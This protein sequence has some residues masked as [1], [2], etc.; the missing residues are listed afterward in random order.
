[1]M[2]MATE[3]QVSSTQSLLLSASNSV[4]PVELSPSHNEQ[5]ARANHREVRMASPVSEGEQ[6]NQLFKRVRLHVKENPIRVSEEFGRGTSEGP[7]F[8]TAERL[9]LGRRDSLSNF[10]KRRSSDLI[11]D[12]SDKLNDKCNVYEE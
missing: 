12:L 1:M 3:M 9:S 4:P 7:C 10:R 11:D 6:I 5:V 2:I 8:S